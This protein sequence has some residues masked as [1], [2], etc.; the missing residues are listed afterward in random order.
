MS[1]KDYTFAG[2]SLFVIGMLASNVHKMQN[3]DQEVVLLKHEVALYQGEAQ[4]LRDQIADMT[5]QFSSRKTYEEGV[6][7]GIH[8]SKSH[9]YMA[10]YH[11][12]VGQL[13]SVPDESIT[14]TEKKQ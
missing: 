8:N 9:E 6:M 7:D 14:S 13:L 3:R 12:A 11:L 4:I 1:I 2:F 5:Y 10:G